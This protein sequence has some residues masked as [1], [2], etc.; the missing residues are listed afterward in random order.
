MGDLL[1]IVT[2]QETFPGSFR[3]EGICVHVTRVL[4]DKKEYVVVVM[5]RVSW[6]S[7]NVL[8]RAFWKSTPL[9]QQCVLSSGMEN[10]SSYACPLYESALPPLQ[11]QSG[12]PRL[13][14]SVSAQ[15]IIIEWLGLERTRAMPSPFSFCSECLVWKHRRCKPLVRT[16]E[17]F[18]TGYTSISGLILMNVLASGL[19]FNFSPSLPTSDWWKS[20]Q[21]HLLVEI[22]KPHLF[23]QN[24]L[25]WYTIVTIFQ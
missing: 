11:F 3:L 6:C 22:D 14:P 10:N 2:L 12:R 20:K 1:K 21:I 19:N 15:Y 7:C 4:A 5:F 25:L 13:L 18:W 9:I 24:I 16:D 17:G 23:F 8:P